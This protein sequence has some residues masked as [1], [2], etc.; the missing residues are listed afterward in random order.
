MKNKWVVL[1]FVSLAVLGVLFVSCAY[2]FLSTASGAR[3]IISR[4]FDHYHVP[5]DAE[6]KD[7]DGTLSQQLVLRDIELKNI[8]GWPEEVVVRIQKADIYFASISPQSLNIEVHNARVLSPSLGTIVVNAIYQESELE[9]DVFSASLDISGLRRLFPQAHFLKNSSG[10]IGPIDLVLK[11]NSDILKVEG[12]L[13]ICDF[14]KDAIALKDVAIVLNLVLKDLASK[15]RLSGEAAVNEG[16]VVLPSAVF[17]LQS[18]KITFRGDASEPYLDIK[19]DSRIEGAD[20]VASLTGQP[21]ALSLRLSSEPPIPQEKLAMMVLTGIGDLSFRYDQQ[22]SAFSLKK[23]FTDR[24]ELSYGVEQPQ[25]TGSK[26]RQKLG[27]SC[28]LT[29]VFSIEGRKELQLQQASDDK[30]PARRP[31]DAVYLKYNKKF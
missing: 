7:I 29:D 15:L 20:V 13:Q 26:S 3:F 5:F 22:S 25:L 21:S 14:S 1:I 10:I 30:I 4:L 24:V 27:M 12:N 9:A 11:G 2:Y 17:S 19:G 16:A 6:I 28:R 31:D 8:E 23:A 18:G